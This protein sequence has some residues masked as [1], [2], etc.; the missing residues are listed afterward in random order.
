MM[1]LLLVIIFLMCDSISFS[2]MFLARQFYVT[3]NGFYREALNFV[4]GVMA[5]FHGGHCGSFGE[6]CL[7]SVG[8]EP[9]LSAPVDVSFSVKNL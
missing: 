8:S 3:G 5:L 9:E 4:V 7:W 1:L 2:E 6:G